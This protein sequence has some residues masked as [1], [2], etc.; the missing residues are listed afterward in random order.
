MG[1][2]AT[3]RGWSPSETRA[4]PAAGWLPPGTEEV[5]EGQWSLR[6]RPL[7]PWAPPDGRPSTRVREGK[8]LQAP[9]LRVLP[10]GTALVGVLNPTRCPSGSSAKSSLFFL[11]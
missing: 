2:K 5:R 3:V 4:R 9:R 7:Q 11:F 6:G 10:P 8:A 1:G